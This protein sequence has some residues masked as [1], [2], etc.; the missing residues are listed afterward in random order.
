MISIIICSRHTDISEELKVNIQATIG[1]EYELVIIDNSKNKYSIFQAYNE[2]VR[3][4]KYPYLCFMHEDI[5]YHTQDWGE[6]VVE[7]FKDEKVGL[8]GTIGSH[9]LP[10]TPSG[11]YQSKVTSGGGLVSVSKNGKIELERVGDYTHLKDQLSIEAVAIDGLW[12]CTPK[13]IFSIVYFDEQNFKGFHCYDLDIC[14]QIRKAGF[15]VRIISDILLDHSTSTG[16]F[17]I[18]WV[19]NTL[20]FFNKWEKDLPQVAGINLS[21]LEIKIRED[22]VKEVF[23]WMSAYAQSSAELENVRRSKAY[24]LGKCLIK[25]FPFLKKM[26]RKQN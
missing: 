21:S 17:P 5:L 13:S 9:F 19:K 16:K 24:R 10:K 12:F 11:W 4:A 1:L 23:L 3:R 20:L 6:K 26:V 2:G 18:E 22:M 14:L 8:I 25:P 15:Q 7:H